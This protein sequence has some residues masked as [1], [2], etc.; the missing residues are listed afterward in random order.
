MC[1]E[2]FREVIDLE[3]IFKGTPDEFKEL[4]ELTLTDIHFEPDDDDDC[5]C[6]ECEESSAEEIAA[7]EFVQTVAD[8]AKKFF[9]A[10][11]PKD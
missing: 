6:A 4:R 9:K 5:D 7:A 10:T 8:A 2:T 1:I 11:Q 3:L